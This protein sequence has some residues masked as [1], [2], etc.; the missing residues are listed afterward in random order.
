MTIQTKKYHTIFVLFFS[1][2]LLTF[3]NKANANESKTHAFDDIT[4]TA[5]KHEQKIQEIPAAVSVFTQTDIKDA[6][7][8]NLSD[9]MNLV[10]N[11][12]ANDNGG[13]REVSFRG[14]SS[15]KYTFKN[16]VVIYIDGVPND[17]VPFMDIDL[18][19]VE[20]V[21]VLRGAQGVLYGKNAIGGI[22][23][24]ITKQPG[25]TMEGK[26]STEIAEDQT[27]GVKAYING[28][29]INNKLF[30]SLSENYRQTDGYMTN[31][32]PDED[33]YDG[34][35]KNSFRAR[36]NWI[37][38][39]K[40][41]MDFNTSFSNRSGGHTPTIYKTE[42]QVSYHSYKN[43][44]DELTKDIFNSSLGINYSLENAELK[45]ITTYSDSKIERF[46]ERLHEGA[47]MIDGGMDQ[48]VIGFTQELRIQSPGP[49]ALKW[50]GG[51]FF[52]KEDV[53]NKN[54]FAAFNTTAMLGY[55]TYMD[56]PAKTYNDTLAAFGEVTLPFGK[57]NFTTGLRYEQTDIEMDYKYEES[58]TDTKELVK[59]PVTYHAED[60]WDTFIPKGVISWNYNDNFMVYTS[61]AKGYLAG[62][63][64]FC[65]ANKDFAR[66]DNQTSVNYEMGIKTKSFDNRLI[67]NAA[68]YYMDIK[69]IHVLIEG[70]DSGT[71]V[72]SN[73]G[74]AHSQGIEIEAILDVMNG[75]DI[76]AALGMIGGEYDEYIF[77]ETT[78]YSGKKLIRTPEYSFNFAISYRHDSGF[79]AR[80]DIIGYGDS[81]FDSANTKKQKAYEIYNAKIGY[82]ASSWELYC[83]GKNIFDQEYFTNIGVLNNVG[84]PR[85][86]GLIAALKF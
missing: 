60:D 31:D 42:N 74:A 36:L 30:F 63:Y 20:R 71:F 22:V 64:N 49:N 76:T 1:V 17:K 48:E 55:D 4:V 53:D 38:T 6:N 69:D 14:L 56:W 78:D 50:M 7:I 43:P 62:G 51:L 3:F 15:S 73:A 83:Y 46:S 32:H 24:I 21:E 18:N 85:V 54:M 8:N 79:F 39:D 70:I 66:I 44:D 61:V 47:S 40:M 29:I 82:E 58:R 72:A 75:L 37:P 81:Y 77:D 67:L 2:V 26:I 41:E 45:S 57:F 28:P 52:S 9:I 25:N 16:P 13:F 65:E 35:H 86:F 10:P 12:K 84:S 68:M 80:A 34:F 59:D 11:L 19:N 33:T 27:Y 23:N 5:N